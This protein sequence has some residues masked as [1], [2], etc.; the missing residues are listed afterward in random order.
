MAP[1]ADLDCN[2]FDVWAIVAF[3]GVAVVETAQRQ[4]CRA[5]LRQHKYAISSIDFGR[6]LGPAVVALGDKCQW[7]DQFGYRLAAEDRNLDALRDG[8]DF[9]LKPGQGH[10][11]EL[12]NAEAAHREDPR[13][14]R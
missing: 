11:L 14:S 8:F 10:V 9:G 3:E 6:G 7:E 1:F 12:L 2:R 13:F 4:A 5:W